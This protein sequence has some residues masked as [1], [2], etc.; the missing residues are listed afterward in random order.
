MQTKIYTLLNAMKSSH[1]DVQIKFKDESK[2]MKI[3]KKVMFFNKNFPRY[4]TTIGSNIYFTSREEFQYREKYAPKGLFGTIAHEYVHMWDDK[5]SRWFKLKYLFPQILTIFS[6]LALLSFISPLFIVF[7]A[8]LI[9][10]YPF[11][12]EG[13]TEAELRG[14][15]MSLLVDRLIDNVKPEDNIRLSHIV[16]NFNTG[17]YYYMCKDVHYVRSELIRRANMN[18]EELGQPYEKV[19]SILRSN[20]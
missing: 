8:F 1:P 18:P 15:T 16:S 7:L 19:A 14:Y 4:T 3:L 5:Q 11:H 6:L 12:S 17:A 10:A 2:F 20:Q 9:F 13:R